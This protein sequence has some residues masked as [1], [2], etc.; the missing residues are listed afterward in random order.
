MENGNWNANKVMEDYGL[1]DEDQV[2]DIN[3]IDNQAIASTEE[4]IE[5]YV[6]PTRHDYSTDEAR[7]KKGDH[8]Q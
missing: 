1:L 3:M 7:Q 4:K 8:G 6:A 2:E 5:N